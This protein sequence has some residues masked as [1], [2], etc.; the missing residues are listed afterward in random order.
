M[1]VM[2]ERCC[3]LDVHKARITACVRMPGPDGKRVSEIRTFGTTTS[4]L[5]R[6]SDWVMESGCTHV[7]MESTGIYW[8]PV[9]NIL[10][11]VAVVLL[12][13]ARDAKNLPG[14]KTDVKDCE[15]IAEMLEHG[16]LRS[17]FIPP[18][19]I[20]DL[21]DLTRYRKSLIGVRADEVNRLQKVLETANIKL[22][23]VVTDV[24]GASGRSMV[25]ALIAGERDTARLVQ[26]AK[27]SLKKKQDALGAAMQGRFRDHHA[28]IA[29]Q[30]L[31][32]IEQIEEHITECGRRIEECLRPFS[33]FESLVQT[34]PGVRQRGSEGILA[35]VGVEMTCFGSSSRLASWTGLC[36]GNNES[37]GKRLSGRTRPGNPWLKTLM[38][39]CAWAAIR[40]KN[41][42]CSALFRRIAR[43]RGP[44]RAILAVA[45]HLIV[46]VFH[47]LAKRQPYRELG[48]HYFD[49][50]AGENA[51]K[52][53]VRRLQAMGFHVTLTAAA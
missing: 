35:E 27:G 37:A 3:G 26:M 13:N 11:E 14:R 49:K 12:V 52:H 42:Y 23:S 15:W 7:A 51:R 16:L 41:S 43:R 31:D 39:E 21:R 30:I 1:R 17:S 48:S 4:E 36:P 45:H 53:Y 18:E 47:V 33:E 24:M 8:R 29:N 10:E 38:V 20:R 46:S 5:L 22:T 2:Y 44:K 34:I 25:K 50:L 19:P 40:V 32:H 28:F 9:F 6:L